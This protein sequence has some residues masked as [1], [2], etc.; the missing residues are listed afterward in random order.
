MKKSRTREARVEEEERKRE[1]ERRG[2]EK[3]EEDKIAIKSGR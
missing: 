3:P 1:G 2:R